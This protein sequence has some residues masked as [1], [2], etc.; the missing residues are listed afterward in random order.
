[1]P[2]DAKITRKDPG[3]FIFLV[4]QSGSMEDPQAGRGDSSK[5]VNV[6]DA[7]NRLLNNIV[8]R[9]SSG[10]LVRDYFSVAI[11]GYGNDRVW[12][13]W[14]G[15]IAGSTFVS[16][17]QLD[18][19][20][21]RIEARL[22]RV[23]D[24][25]GGEREISINVPVYL[26]PVAAGST[27]MCKALENACNL[28]EWWVQ[29]H[30]AGFPPIVLNLTDGE[31]TDGDPVSL[32][33]KLTSLQTANGNVLLFNLHVSSGAGSPQLYPLDDVG[34]ADDFARRLFS[35]SSK[36][37]SPMLQAAMGLGLSLAPGSRGFVYNADPAQLVQ[38]LE[39]GT[40]PNTYATSP[41][42]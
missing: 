13:P 6:A 18:A 33:Q 42:R 40:T 14:Q 1:M 21:A 23:A 38:F 11:V 2:Y 35:M 19:N 41:D 4:D 32:A 9:S 8:V 31:A 27:P 5:A 26:D 29:R 7:I 37:P 22:E 3:L 17:S 36:L 15:D 10:N 34:L 16:T 25:V 28:C 39:I 24:G 20:P 12:S 30:Q